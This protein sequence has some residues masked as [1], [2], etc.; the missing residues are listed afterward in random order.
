MNKIS[1]KELKFALIL[2]AGYFLFTIFTDWLE[3]F[4]EINRLVRF[5]LAC[6][7]GLVISVIVHF[8]KL[9]K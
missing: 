6:V 4:W 5:L 8:T 7:F 9:D 2:I 3:N 1:T